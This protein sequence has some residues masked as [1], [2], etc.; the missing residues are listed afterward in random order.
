[1]SLNPD[2]RRITQKTN[3][4]LPTT[5]HIPSLPQCP[6][7]ETS[8]FCVPFHAIIKTWIFLL[9]LWLCSACEYIV[10][11]SICASKAENLLSSHWQRFTKSNAMIY[12]SAI[13]FERHSPH[14][15][16]NTTHSIYKNILYLAIVLLGVQFHIRNDV[17]ILQNAWQLCNARPTT[18]AYIDSMYKL[19]NSYLCCS[20]YYR[21]WRIA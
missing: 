8:K 4:E 9:A 19:I 20:M 16:I 1:M 5:P 15:N 10:Y 7:A 17:L 18:Q 21:V 2:S 14:S 3:I 13:G 12:Q 6:T 11:I